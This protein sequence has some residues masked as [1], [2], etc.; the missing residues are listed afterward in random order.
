MG[1]KIIEETILGTSHTMNM[2]EHIADTYLY[3]YS[4]SPISLCQIIFC[5]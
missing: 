1:G 2:I 4:I 3:Y 5:Y